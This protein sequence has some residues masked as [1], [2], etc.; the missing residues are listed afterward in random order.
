MVKWSVSIEVYKLKNNSL[1]KLCKLNYLAL[2]LTNFETQKVTL[3][4][5][6]L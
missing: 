3:A 4:F 1:C 2:F 6:R 5:K